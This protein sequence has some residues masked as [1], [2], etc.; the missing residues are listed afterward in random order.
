MEQEAHAAHSVLLLLAAATVAVGAARAL[1]VSP[2]LGYLLLGV[3]MGPT[4]F[5]LIADVETTA[6]IAE[7]GVVFLLFTIGLELPLRRLKAMRRF[8]FGFGMAQVGLCGAALGGIALALGLPPGAAVIIGG[9]LALS[10]TA[11]VVQ[12]LIERGEFQ[13]RAGRGAFAMLLAQDIAVA[14]LLAAAGLLAGGAAM[15]ASSPRLDA[16]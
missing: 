2:I 3:A 16:L 11:M 8:V 10:S 7:Y 13:T 4:G 6:E 5:S 14:P 9:A 12:L 15:D 1:H